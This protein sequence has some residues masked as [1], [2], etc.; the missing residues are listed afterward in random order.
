[1]RPGVFVSSGSIS[2]GQWPRLYSINQQTKGWWGGVSPHVIR[3]YERCLRLCT[4][5][6][7]KSGG[8]NFEGHVALRRNCQVSSSTTYNGWACTAQREPAKGL[9]MWNG[10]GL[11]WWRFDWIKGEI[12]AFVYLGPN[13]TVTMKQRTWNLCQRHPDQSFDMH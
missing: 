6:F 13:A 11:L 10:E 2:H 9:K 4:S 7:N 5:S 8:E 12:F 3:L 1:M